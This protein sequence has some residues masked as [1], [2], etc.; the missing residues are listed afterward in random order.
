MN[1]GGKLVRGG[2]QRLGELRY[3]IWYDLV[4]RNS[5]LLYPGTA[6]ADISI[7]IIIFGD[8]PLCYYALGS[9]DI[10]YSPRFVH[11]CSTSSI[12]SY[13]YPAQLKT[14]VCEAPGAGIDGTKAGAR[15]FHT[16]HGQEIVSHQQS[17]AVVKFR[18]HPA[19]GNICP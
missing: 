7:V 18:S 13:H 11:R 10:V 12:Q 4:P 3:E 6:K 1:F 15:A 19:G 17:M 2:T 14:R 9:Y 5:I 8:D 16:A